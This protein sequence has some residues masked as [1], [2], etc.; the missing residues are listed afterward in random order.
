M[1]KPLYQIYINVYKVIKTDKKVKRS[2]RLYIIEA[3]LEYLV[4]LLVAGSFL[5]TL[6]GQLGFSD[7]ATGILSQFISL[8][9]VFQLI[10]IG[11]R[12]KKAKPTVLAL[13]IANQLL[14]TLLY[15]LPISGNRGLFSKILFVIVVLAA[16]LLYNIA[17]PKKIN[18][19]MSLVEDK[20][21]GNF[22]ANKEIISLISGMIF[23]FAMGA[24]VDCFKAQNNIKAALIICAATLFVLTVLHTLTVIFTVEKESEKTPLENAKLSKR[25]VSLI[26]DKK[27]RQVSVLFIIWNIANSITTPFTHTFMLNDLDISLTTITVITAIGSLGRIAVSKF[28]GNYADKNSFAKMDM[29]CFGVAAMA[30]A[31]VV[32]ATPANKYI[33][34]TGFHLLHAVSMGGI[35]SSLIN[36]IF[37]FV[38]FDKRADSLAITQVLGGLSG[39]A[40][41]MCVSPFVNFI[42]N[43]GNQ[44]CGLTV[45][46]QQIIAVLSVF[47]AI[48]AMVYTKKSLVDATDN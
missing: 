8:G 14:F 46:A 45:Y 5:A 32:F 9:Y 39:F 33:T 21:R 22:T 37:D 10:S 17:H 13:S 12:P 48:A 38:P 20:E 16:Y 19:F 2:Q 28:W 40:T 23:S 34:M 25:I 18:W 43:S 41:T 11:F 3:A 47:F 42:Q 6:T 27:I 30:F 24:C 31:F 29:L 44:I 1:P 26:K 4:S 36:L 15:I 35:S 7:G